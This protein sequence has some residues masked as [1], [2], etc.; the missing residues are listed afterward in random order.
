M[1]DWLMN[2]VDWSRPLVLL[3]GLKSNALSDYS[4]NSLICMTTNIFILY[5]IYKTVDQNRV[6]TGGWLI[7]LNRVNC[8]HI[9]VKLKWTEPVCSA[10]PRCVSCKQSADNPVTFD[11]R[12]IHLMFLLCDVVDL[13]RSSS[14][15]IPLGEL[16]HCIIYRQLPILSELNNFK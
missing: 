15:Y 2:A 9:K 5:C 16:L 11:T 10:A 12:I 8:Q 14:G 3:K 1:I 4:L 7:V 13:S 6:E